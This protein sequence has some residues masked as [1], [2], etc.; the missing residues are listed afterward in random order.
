MARAAH[1]V[2]A[3]VGDRII[4]VGQFFFAHHGRG[5]CGFAES[6]AVFRAPHV[7]Q[8]G[9][10]VVFAVQTVAQVVARI[11]RHDRSALVRAHAVGLGLCTHLVHI[12]PHGD[13]QIRLALHL[14]ARRVA[15]ADVRGV[16]Q[17]GG[18]VALDRLSGLERRVKVDIKAGVAVHT[19]VFEQRAAERLDA[20]PLDRRG[21]RALKHMGGLPAFFVHVKRLGVYCYVVRHQHGDKQVDA[22]PQHVEDQR[23]EGLHAESLP[24]AAEVERLIAA[25][26]VIQA[27]RALVVA[28]ALEFAPDGSGCRIKLHGHPPPVRRPSAQRGRG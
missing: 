17:L 23:I 10:P 21:E 3:Q 24:L 12:A 27:D 2:P 9:H 16:D 25:H 6:D 20:R 22:A 11:V 19:G 15:E 7:Q 26:A 18:N 4:A 1:P 13:D 14:V 28:V 8:H 5:A